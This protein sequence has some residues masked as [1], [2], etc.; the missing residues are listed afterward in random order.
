MVMALLIF[1]HLL[2]GHL[3]LG[4]GGTSIRGFAHKPP[5]SMP[6]GPKKDNAVRNSGYPT[7]V[8]RP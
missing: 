8:E 4:Y 2:L 3:L 5:N 6:I 1:C 7:L